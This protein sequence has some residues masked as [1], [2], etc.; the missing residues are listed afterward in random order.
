M[1]S[2]CMQVPHAWRCDGPAVRMASA[3][4]G[5]AHGV[6]WSLHESY[7]VLQPRVAS[8]SNVRKAARSPLMMRVSRANSAAHVDALRERLLSLWTE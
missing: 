8:G 3:W 2:A 7:G 1:S 6:A 5:R 4:A